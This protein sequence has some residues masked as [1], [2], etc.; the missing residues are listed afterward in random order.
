M[1]KFN[2]NYFT[3]N[4]LTID[5]SFERVVIADDCFGNRRVC[6]KFACDRCIQCAK[7]RICCKGD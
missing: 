6:D 2:D 4:S 5:Y 3:K 1:A 7:E